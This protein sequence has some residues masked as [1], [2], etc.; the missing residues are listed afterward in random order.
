MT[1]RYTTVQNGTILHTASTLD[2][3]FKALTFLAKDEQLDIH[4][5][6]TAEAAA[7]TVFYIKY[8]Y[9]CLTCNTLLQN[10]YLEWDIMGLHL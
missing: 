5:K 6:V 7:L 1:K 9:I 8:L 3:G 10:I 2:A 4:A